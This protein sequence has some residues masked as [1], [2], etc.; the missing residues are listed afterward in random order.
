MKSLN[1]TLVIALIFASLTACSDRKAAV[2]PTA[3][4]VD[5]APRVVCQQYTQLKPIGSSKTPSDS[6]P[7]VSA[8]VAL[9]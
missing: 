1:Y 6:S 3:A 4:T 7:A 5:E 8:C 2:A 9:R